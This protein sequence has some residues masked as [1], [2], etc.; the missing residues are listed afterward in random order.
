[1]EYAGERAYK[2]VSSQNVSDAG[3]E[4]DKS[5]HL[6][7]FPS[8]P[9]ELCLIGKSQTL[10]SDPSLQFC[11][12]SLISYE[13]LGKSFNLSERQLLHLQIEGNDAFL[14]GLL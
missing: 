9:R 14:S 7:L 8:N 1:M 4:R 10:D 11:T 5:H 2:K 3:S 13:A 6:V 12:S